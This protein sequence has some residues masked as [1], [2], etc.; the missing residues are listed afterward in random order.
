M[1]AMLA[2]SV[3]HTNNSYTLN[4]SNMLANVNCQRH[5]ENTTAANVAVHDIAKK[6]P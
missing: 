6:Y 5:L 1:Y 4:G 2:P 3:L